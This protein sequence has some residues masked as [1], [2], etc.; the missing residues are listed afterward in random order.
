MRCVGRIVPG[1]GRVGLFGRGGLFMFHRGHRS[2]GG[3]GIGILFAKTTQLRCSGNCSFTGPI[4]TSH[5]GY[6]TFLL[7]FQPCVFNSLLVFEKSRGCWSAAGSGA[8]CL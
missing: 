4:L 3:I 6:F 2:V 5:V 7:F 1:G 8:W